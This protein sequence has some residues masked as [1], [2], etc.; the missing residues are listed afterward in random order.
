MS[1]A[2]LAVLLAALP[3]ALGP[4]APAAAPGEA[5]PAPEGRRDDPLRVYDVRLAVDVPVTAGAAALAFVPYR[6]SSRLIE[7]RCPCDRREVPRFDRFAIGLHSDVADVASDVVVALAVAAPLGWDARRLGLVPALGADVAVLAE[8]LA[9]NSA[10]VVLAKYAA[11]RPLP[12]TYAGDPDLVRRPRGYRSFYSGHA[13]TA[14]SALTAAAWTAHLR[15]GPSAWPW[16]VTAGVGAGVGVLRVA[17]GRHFPS[18]V[19][20]G[21]LAGFGVG[22]VVPLLHARRLSVLPTPHGLAIAARP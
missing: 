15:D 9:V 21:A 8:T 11:Q 7:P 13:S 17:A 12:R 6:L 22:T 19:L 4:A 16:L 14:V 18:D 5:G 20:M 10:L 1:P 3:P 2:A